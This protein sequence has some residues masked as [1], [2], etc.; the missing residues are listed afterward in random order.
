MKINCRCCGKP[1]EHYGQGYRRACHT[2]WMAAGR[3]DA[4]PP[5][6]RT[7]KEIGKLGGQG[8]A[9]KEIRL[10]TFRILRRFRGM[11]IS[12]AAAEL[13]VSVRTAQRYEAELKALQE[14]LV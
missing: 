8:Y 12:E 5:P 3:P 4:G 14:S 10:D 6:P 13:G 9:E 7:S 1:G 2:R 11:A